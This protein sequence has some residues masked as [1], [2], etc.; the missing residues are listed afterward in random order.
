MP[1]ADG[2]ELIRLEQAVGRA[3]ARIRDLE[4]RLEASERRVR[5]L[6]QVLSGV[7]GGDVGPSVLVDSVRALEAENADLRRRLGGGREG[8]ERLLSKIRFLE[9]QR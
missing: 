2:D 6:D 3:V 9:E 7:T 1:G 5:D 8:I 4:G